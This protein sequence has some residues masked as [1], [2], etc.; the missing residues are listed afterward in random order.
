MLAPVK[1]KS[2][3]DGLRP[4]L[5]AT[6][7]S[8]RSKIRSGRGDVAGGRTRRC[9]LMR[10]LTPISPIQ[11]LGR[12]S[13]HRGARRMRPMGHIATFGG[14]RRFRRRPLCGSLRP[15]RDQSGTVPSGSCRHDHGDG[16]DGHGAG[17]PFFSGEGPAACASVRAGPR[18]EE[19]ARR[20][21]R[22][23]RA[24]A[25]TLPRG[26]R[27]ERPAAPKSSPRQTFLEDGTN[28]LPEGRR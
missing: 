14:T 4:P 2:L 19:D 6:A 28:A 8:V 22:Q 15:E 20:R 21:V 23:P 10:A 3:R 24:S 27:R 18:S 12:T 17:G 1:G 9:P 13:S 26:G 5:T 25:R 11:V 7:R 16:D